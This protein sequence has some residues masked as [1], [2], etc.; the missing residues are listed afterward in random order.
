MPGRLYVS[1]WRARVDNSRAVRRPTIRDVGRGS[2]RSVAYRSSADDDENSYEAIKARCLE[3]GSLWEDPDFPPAAESL[4]YNNPP[5]AWPN[6]DWKRPHVRIF[7]S[8]AIQH[9][10]LFSVITTTFLEE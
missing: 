6:I 2:A 3:S 10:L 1:G 7:I 4:F 5:S 8:T 9:S